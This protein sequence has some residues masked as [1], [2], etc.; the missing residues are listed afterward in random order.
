MNRVETT[1]PRAQWQNI[2]DAAD[3]A[4]PASLREDYPGLHQSYVEI[5]LAVKRGLEAEPAAEAVT[6]GLSPFTLTSI[7]GL[8]EF[9]KLRDGMPSRDQWLEA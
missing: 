8:P 5:Y 6:I 3:K 7:F 4:S 2:R 1:L 9:D